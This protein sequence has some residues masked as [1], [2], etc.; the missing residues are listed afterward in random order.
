MVLIT[1][2]KRVSNIFLANI[3]YMM[4]FHLGFFAHPQKKKIIQTCFNLKFSDTCISP[5][6]SVCF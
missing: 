5:L 1:P 4:G 2:I 3:N 6:A